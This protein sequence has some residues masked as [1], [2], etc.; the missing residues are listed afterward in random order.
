MIYFTVLIVLYGLG[1]MANKIT[2]HKESDK[3]LLFM[4]L[5][6]LFFLTAFRSLA[7][8]NDTY[9]YF[10]GYSRLD[11]YQSLLDYLSKTR[12]EPGYAVLC[13]GCYKAGLSYYGMQTII[14]AF[15]FLSFYRFIK[16]YSPHYLFS[17]FIFL[18]LRYA[19]SAM[20]VVRMLIAVAI[21]LFAVDK[22]KERKPFQFA[23]IVIMA[24]LFHASAIVFIVFYPL[25][26]IKLSRALIIA[27]LGG[28]GVVLL[29]E[30]PLF[31][32]ITRLIGRYEGYLQSVFFNYNKNIAIYL[33]LLIH[34]LLFVFL[35]YTYKNDED[36]VM[37]KRRSCIVKNVSM[38]EISLMAGLLVLAIDIIGLRNTIMSRIEAYFGILYIVSIPLAF[39]DLE[40][41]NK[42]ILR[43]ALI[44]ALV[45]QFY[46]VMI[47]RPNWNGV[48]PY[49]FFW[50]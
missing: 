25:A 34:T 3:W 22:L 14:S 12:Y 4:A 46:V 49:R 16:K 40:K 2:H 20:N 7:V 26:R 28:A 30:R 21:L 33:T 11:Q 8:G 41:K 1:S 38:R 44:I 6:F 43:T 5:F 27:V 10:Y 48:T 35:L 17:C 9:T 45:L 18:T 15:I 19:I 31:I 36:P 50:E 32:F 47:L 37:N 29:F 42:A 23:A 24:A 13:Y 39:T